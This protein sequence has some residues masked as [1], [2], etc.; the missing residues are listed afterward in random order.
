M[1]LPKLNARMLVKSK[2]A[3]LP[4]QTMKTPEPDA[5]PKHVGIIIDGNRRWAKQR[6]LAPLKGHQAGA[7]TLKKIAHAAFERDIK[8][9]SLYVFSTENWKRPPAEI[10]GY[11][12]LL[13]KFLNEE[14]KEFMK[15]NIKLR[16]SGLREHVEAKVLNEFDKAVEMTKHNTG[17]VINFC[18]NYGGRSD[19]LR[20][21][22][23]MITKGTKV[24]DVTEESFGKELSTAGMYDVDL[25]IRTSERRLS[26]F[27]PWEA[28]YAEI[29]FMP[30]RLWPDFSVADLDN[31][32]ANY[33]NT[34]RRFGS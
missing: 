12:K 24:R 29:Y 23:R 4:K 11:M 34:Q 21:V 15:R 26:N 30:E 17:G 20:A 2:L 14:L 1:S 18:F 9:V 6:G 31:A 10:A 3:Q 13:L 22:K 33:A 5:V 27:L 28:V 32:L 7:E 8:E 25:V 19:I 16:I